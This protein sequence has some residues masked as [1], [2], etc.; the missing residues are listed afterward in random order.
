MYFIYIY[1]MFLLNTD[2]K[3]LITKKYKINIPIFAFNVTHIKH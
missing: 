3:F 2:D 1:L